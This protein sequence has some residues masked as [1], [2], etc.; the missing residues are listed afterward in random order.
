[1]AIKNKSNRPLVLAKK[2]GRVK[3]VVNLKIKVEI[4]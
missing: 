1:M 4:I 2:T 3:E